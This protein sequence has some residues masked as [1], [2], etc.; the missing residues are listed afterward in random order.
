MGKTR[1]SALLLSFGVIVIL[2]ISLGIFSW[3]MRPSPGDLTLMAQ[4]LAITAVISILIGYGAYRSNWLEHTPSLR[5]ALL[6][7]YVLASLLTFINVW[8]T[9]RLMFASEHDLQLATVLLLFAGG[10]AVALGGFFTSALIERI[11]RLETATHA[12]AEGDLSARAGIPGNDEIAALAES[13]NRMADQLQM[14]DNKQKELDTLRRDLIAWAGHDLRTPLSSIRLLVEALSDGV[15]T[16]P[17]IVQNYLLQAEKHINSLSLLVDDLFQISQLDAGGLPLNLEMASLSDLISDTLESFSGMAAQKGISLSGSVGAGVDPVTIDVL[18][19]GRALNNVVSNAISHTPPKGSVTLSANL[20]GRWVQV[21]IS[22][23]GEGISP[24][25]L[26]HI[27]ERFYRGEKSRSR[28]TGGAGLGL[29]IARGIIEAHDGK[30]E[31]QSKHGE[32]TVF[33]ISIPKR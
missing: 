33:T 17:E 12:I 18:W 5:W 6:G 22:D 19:M 9:A 8:L 21:S 28:A 30:I 25:D 20:E 27:F 15:V 4:F 31:V 16:D 13:F 29:A 11:A 1:S 2:L 3:L 24:D 32:G 14:A 7:T 10:I 23:T 26:P